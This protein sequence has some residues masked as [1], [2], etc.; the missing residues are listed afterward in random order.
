MKRSPRRI[1]VHAWEKYLTVEEFQELSAARDAV[2][3][4]E[5]R[6]QDTFSTALVQVIIIPTPIAIPNPRAPNP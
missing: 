1:G 5:L 4:V 6:L 3:R 2:D